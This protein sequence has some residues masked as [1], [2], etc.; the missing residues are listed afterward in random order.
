MPTDTEPGSDGQLNGHRAA[1][2]QRPLAPASLDLFVGNL[3]QPARNAV[4]DDVIHAPRDCTR[5]GRI[6]F[7]VRCIP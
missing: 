3:L 7:H 5:S 1:A 4:I 6:V 2:D